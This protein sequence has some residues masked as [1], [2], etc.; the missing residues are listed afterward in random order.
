MAQNVVV[1]RARG[2]RGAQGPQGPAGAS[3][4]ILGSYVSLS[5]L[6]A[7]HPTGNTGDGYLIGPNLYIWTNSQWTN[8]GPIQGPAGPQGIPGP[9]GDTG[10]TGATGA[11]GLKGDKGDTGSQ[12]PQ[13]IPGPQGPKGDT[14]ATGPQG[15]K[16]DPGTNTV[17]GFDISLVSAF[18]EQQT[19][20]I[21]SLTD[22]LHGWSITHNLHFKP[23]VTVMDY[24]SNQ[25]ECDISYVS[26]DKVRLK[27]SESI[28][29]YAYL[30]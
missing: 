9:K 10:A 1:V 18:Y 30:S 24:G 20:A 19:P 4:Y 29:G 15:P 21:G 14:G 6:Q 11:T 8:A 17:T 25:V 7:A 12:G 22:D 3:I 5:A 16:G 27:F 13:G 28:S 26:V 2:A 23:N